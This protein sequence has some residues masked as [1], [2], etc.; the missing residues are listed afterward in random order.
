M[1]I[2]RTYTC[3]DK[4]QSRT[5][6]L[7]ISRS[8]CRRASFPSTATV[9][10]TTTRP[11]LHSYSGLSNSEICTNTMKKL[12]LF[13]LRSS[14]FARF[15]P[16]VDLHRIQQNRLSPPLL[17]TLATFTILISGF[18]PV[19]TSRGKEGWGNERNGVKQRGTKRGRSSGEEGGRRRAERGGRREEE[20]RR[21]REGG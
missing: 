17:F 3:N 4:F 21:R 19:P 12:L 20:R 1:S 7:A 2:S 14:Q 16:R 10:L 5:F 15:L 6:L 13:D 11:T 9:T 8:D 18:V